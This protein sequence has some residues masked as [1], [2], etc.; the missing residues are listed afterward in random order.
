MLNNSIILILGVFMSV[1][2]LKMKEMVKII[3]EK[4]SKSLKTSANA[5]YDQVDIVVSVLAMMFFQDPSMLKFQERLGKDNQLKNIKNLFLLKEV[6]S[7]NQIRNILDKIDSNILLSLYQELA[8]EL[9]R[10]KKLVGFTWLKDHYLI[11][12]D[13][14]QYFTS[15]NINCKHCLTTK[16]TNGEVSYSHKVLQ[17]SIVDPTQNINTSVINSPKY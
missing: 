3:R 13:G 14:T 4:L 9:Q 12:L 2:K 15:K 10:S 11:P 5:K 16:H 17:A 6:A 7:S 8:R 1:K